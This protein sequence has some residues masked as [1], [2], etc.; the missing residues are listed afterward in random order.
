ML[1]GMA[2]ESSVCCQEKKKQQQQQQQHT[3]DG[4]SLLEL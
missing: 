2:T 4:F 1:M 3:V